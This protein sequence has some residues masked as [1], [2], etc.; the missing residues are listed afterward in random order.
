MQ[1]ENAYKS[2]GD[3]QGIPLMLRL[4]INSAGRC[5]WEL[6]QSYAC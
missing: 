1:H 2:C 3:G 5:V 6:V 4:G